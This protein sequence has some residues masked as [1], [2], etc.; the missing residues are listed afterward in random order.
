MKLSYWFILIK[1]LCLIFPSGELMLRRVKEN[2]K[3]VDT[4]KVKYKFNI[5]PNSNLL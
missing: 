1:V 4:E 2:S 3:G 5:V